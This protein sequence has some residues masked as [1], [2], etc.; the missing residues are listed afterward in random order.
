MCVP[1]RVEWESTL[2][3]ALTFAAVDGF[4]LLR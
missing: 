1:A 2:P 3:A 4:R